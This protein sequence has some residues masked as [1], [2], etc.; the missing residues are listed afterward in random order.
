MEDENNTFTVA[1]VGAGPV[2]LVLAI[3][4][5]QRNVSCVVLDEKAGPSQHPQAN[6]TQARTME[7]Y[8]RLGFADEFRS[9]GLPPE[10]PT[11][12]AYYTRYTRLQLCRIKGPSPSAAR[13]IVR[14]SGGAWSTPELPH[15]CSSL[16]FEPVLRKHA[17]KQ[18]SVTLRY[19]WRVTSFKEQPGTVQI[20][21]EPADGG[22]PKTFSADYLVGCDGARSLVR[23]S[24]AIGLSG[25]GERRRDF[26]GG[27]VHATYFR[28]KDLYD[29]VPGGHAVMYFNINRERR[30][31]MQSINGVDTFVFHAQ[32]KPEEEDD[33]IT[34]RQLQHFFRQ[35]FGRDLQVETISSV[36]W[37]AGFALVADHYSRGRVFLAGDAVH[38]FTPTGGLGYNTGV[39]DACNLGWKLAAV[40]NGWGG[41][42]LLDSYERERRPIGV[43]NTTIARSFADNI[44]FYLPGPHLEEESAAGE[45]ERRSAAKFLEAHLRCEFNIPGVSFGVRYDDSPVVVSDGTSPPPDA[46]NDYTPSACPGGRTPHAWLAEGDSLFDHFGPGFTLLQMAG[47]RDDARDF[48]QV[49]AE[50]GIPLTLLYIRNKTLRELYEADLALLRPDQHV[51]WRGAI[52][53]SSPEAIL[54][55]AVGA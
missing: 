34:P 7:H 30:S 37:H 4:L 19:G 41:P 33:Q 18:A 43:R 45:A 12:I 10:F 23:R 26:M 17:E 36:P 5:G 14:H 24:L 53:T 21:A 47:K 1:I 15:R 31:F 32:L 16:F 51:A 54:P 2:G 28:S 44:G 9:L 13:R 52:G 27:K 40:A 48:T 49:A 46:V 55:Q 42:A 39:D 25:E 6:L 8:R 35:A 11:D 22:P 3:E 38:L 29:Q 20:L 50:R